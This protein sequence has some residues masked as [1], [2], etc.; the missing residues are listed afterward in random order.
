MPFI[1]GLFDLIMRVRGYYY[2]TLENI[3]AFLLNPFTILALL[4]I[5]VIATVGAM[6]DI[7]AVIFILD[8]SSQGQKVH[9]QQVVRFSL[10]NA[11]RAWKPKKLY[12]CHCG[13]FVYA[14]CKYRNGVGA[15]V[16][17]IHT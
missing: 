17:N 7:S 8:Q 2:L 16:N 5:F 1:W 12:A 14:P 15:S 9:L 11:L 6:I 10:K 13:A 4:L 3:G